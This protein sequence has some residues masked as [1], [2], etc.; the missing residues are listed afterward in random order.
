MV[1]HTYIRTLHFL[2]HSVP[3]ADNRIVGL[4]IITLDYD[5]KSETRYV[6]DAHKPKSHQ[7]VEKHVRTFVVYT[8]VHQVTAIFTYVSTKSGGTYSTTMNLPT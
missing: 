8:Y 6:D 4:H 3:Q 2:S 7:A 1:L 5:S